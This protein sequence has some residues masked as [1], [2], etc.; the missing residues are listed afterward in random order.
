MYVQG[1]V[2]CPG[3]G[4]GMVATSTRIDEFGYS[5]RYECPKCRWKS[6]YEYGDSEAVAKDRAQ[7]TALIRY[8]GWE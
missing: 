5:A 1:K 8:K 6:P 4:M 2:K 7:K 3:C